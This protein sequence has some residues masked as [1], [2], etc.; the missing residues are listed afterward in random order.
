ME[1]INDILFF[2]MVGI[3]LAGIIVLFVAIIKSIKELKILNKNSDSRKIE[4]A[5]KR[6]GLTPS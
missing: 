6:K 3:I 1:E 4:D 2:V 5:E